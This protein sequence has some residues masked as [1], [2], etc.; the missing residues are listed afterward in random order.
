MNRNRKQDVLSYLQTNGFF[1]Q[2]D[3]LAEKLNVSPSTIRR[4]LQ[5]LEAEGKIKRTHG[6]AECIEMEN[7]FTPFH[8][9]THK[10]IM[11]KMAICRRAASVLKD[12]YV[13]F[14]DASSTT[15]YLSKFFREFSDLKIITNNLQTVNALSSSK[16]EVY[17]TGGKL[18]PSNPV[19]FVGNKALEFVHSVHADVCFMSATAIDEKGGVY[20]IFED[21]IAVRQEMLRHADKAYLLADGEKFEKKAPFLLADV[22]SFDRIFCNRMMKNY[23]EKGIHVRVEGDS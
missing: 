10:K 18:S 7:N 1:A 15:Y 12:G 2:T 17:C 9:R 20:D 6:G 16:L 13:V 21:E 11:E 14:C 19:A 4:D 3:K 5:A 22:R 8:I 23:F